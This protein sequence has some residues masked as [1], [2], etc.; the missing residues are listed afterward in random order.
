MSDK[1]IIIYDQGKK[2]EKRIPPEVLQLVL[3]DDMAVSLREVEKSLKKEEFE[4]K[5]DPRTL[6]ATDKVQFISLVRDHPLT[7]WVTAYFYNDDPANSVYISINN[8]YEWNEI[9]KGEE[10]FKDRLKA[11]R[12]IELIY[13]KC[14]PGKTASVRVLG[15]Y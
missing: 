9:K 8:P 12:R 5:E 3:L 4:G 14:D 6:S 1:E 10:S 11:D 7:P 13:Y 2:V 15:K